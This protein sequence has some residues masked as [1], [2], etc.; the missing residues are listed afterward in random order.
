MDWLSGLDDGKFCGPET[1]K[2]LL[3]IDHMTFA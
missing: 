2:K 1:E 3:E